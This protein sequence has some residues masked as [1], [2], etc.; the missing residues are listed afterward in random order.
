LAIGCSEQ[1][2]PDSSVRQR[3]EDR[4]VQAATDPHSPGKYG[5][6]GVVVN[7]PEFAK[8]FACKPGAATTSA[9]PCRV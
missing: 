4:R 7:L 5:V 1:T 2:N 9:K 3:P 8:T 6:N